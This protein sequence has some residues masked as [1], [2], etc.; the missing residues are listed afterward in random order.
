MGYPVAYTVSANTNVEQR[1]GYV[2]VSGWVHT[3]TQDGVG[4]TIDP[5]NV[6]FEHE[7]GSNTIAVT[8]ANKMVWQARPN[9]DWLSVS[10]TSGMGEGSVT[11]QV[12]PYNEVATRQ[13][14]HAV[15]MLG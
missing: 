4:G 12:A 3:V 14:T 7:G 6:T 5:E 15:H 10:P 13:G 8:A 2:Y 11:Y 9:V 1:T